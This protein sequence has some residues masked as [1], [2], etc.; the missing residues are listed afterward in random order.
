MMKSDGE[1]ASRR[2]GR[3]EQAVAVLQAVVFVVACSCGAGNGSEPVSTTGPG[4]QSDA[5]PQSPPRNATKVAH[6]FVA[7]CD[8][9]NQGIVPVPA[10][11]GNGEDPDRNLY[12]GAAYGVRTFFAKA[13]GWKLLAKIHNPSDAVLERCVFEHSASGA[14]L[15]ADAYRGAEI[16]RTTVEFLGA[17]AGRRRDSVTIGK[18][19]SERTI[20]AGASADLV[21]YVGH[22]GLMD[23]ALPDS[24]TKA[25]EAKRDAIVLACA[26]KA[27]FAEPLR[28]AGA[29]PLLWTTNLMAPEAYVL[30]AALEGWAAGESGESVRVRAATAYDKYQRCGKRSAM[31]L[32]ATGW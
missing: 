25:D 2:S 17:A 6:V 12:W 1:S 24:P 3:F 22:D 4:A 11:I 14:Y 7:L 9:E 10:A 21:A 15:V 29:T 18:Q 28:R 8:N 20:H 19:A 16:R 31:A 5:P 27:Y 26:S 32:F 13:H 23:F 30:A